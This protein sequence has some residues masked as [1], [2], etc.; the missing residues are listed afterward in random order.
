MQII[1][2]NDRKENA[3]R[4]TRSQTAAS[5]AMLGAGAGV[6]AGAISSG[7]IGRA[8][9]TAKAAKAAKTAEG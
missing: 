8:I 5:S 7:A 4:L 3:Y 9:D 6:A 1:P 2:R